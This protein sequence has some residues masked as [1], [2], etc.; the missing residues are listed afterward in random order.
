[1]HRAA[2]LMGPAG[3][4]AVLAGWITTEVGRQPYTVYGLLT[5]AQ[6]ALRDRCRRRGRLAGRVHRRLFRGVRR[7]RVLHPAADGRAAACRRA[8]PAA[9]RADPRRRHHARPALDGGK[10]DALPAE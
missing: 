9:R 2:V 10:A 6:S 4:V 5:T 1:M 8:R 7:R 3:F